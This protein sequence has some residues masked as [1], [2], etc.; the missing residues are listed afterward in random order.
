MKFKIIF[1]LFNIVL[2]FSFVFIFLSPLFIFGEETFTFLL[3]ENYYIAIIFSVFLIF[4]NIYFFKNWKFYSYL[5]REDWNALIAFL[6][7][8]ILRKGKLRKSYIKVFLNA[9]IVTSQIG[10]IQELERLLAVK[11]PAII[12]QYS[13]QFSIPYLLG[14][15]PEDAESFFASLLSQAGT[16][17]RDWIRWNLAF[18]L[19]QQNKTDQAQ[20]ELSGILEARPEFPVVLLTLYMLESYSARDKNVEQIVANEKEQYRKSMTPGKW[21]QLKSSRKQ[22]IESLILSQILSD[23]AAWF[24][25]ETGKPDDETTADAEA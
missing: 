16:C 11:K 2:L 18:S 10:K 6:E 4:F 25:G 9:T 21:T 22:N 13:T 1:L 3:K 23:A 19:L 20:K 7:E 17:D 12:R 8:T 15:K 5:E 14:G 24:F